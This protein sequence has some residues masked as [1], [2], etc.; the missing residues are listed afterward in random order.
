M[1]FGAVRVRAEGGF[2]LMRI[3][4]ERGAI[5]KQTGA[6]SHKSIIIII[7]SVIVNVIVI[8][9]ISILMFIISCVII[10]WSRLMRRGVVSIC[11]DIA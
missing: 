6:S 10:K 7:I 3:F 5:L 1:G 8:I 2:D 4:F 9:I 11:A